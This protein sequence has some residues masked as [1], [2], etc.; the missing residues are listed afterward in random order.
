MSIYDEHPVVYDKL[1]ED[2]KDYEWEAHQVLDVVPTDS[3]SLVNFGCGTGLHDQYFAEELAVVGVDAS[4]AMLDVAEDKNPGAQYVKG[5][6]TSAM[7][8]ESFDVV[9]TLFGVLSYLDDVEDLERAVQ[10]MARHLEEDGVLVLDY[11][12][13]RRNQFEE[14]PMQPYTY[15][16]DALS[17]AR[18]G[19]TE[20]PAE[21][22]LVLRYHTVVATDSG[23]EAFSEVHSLR[24]FARRDY[25]RAFCKAGLEGRLVGDDWPL[26]V[27]ER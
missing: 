7:V 10:N 13:P 12:E 2:M 11:V 16:E 15:R 3:D 8:G 19:V 20:I 24:Q 27:A 22:E 17:V 26:W 18:T 25:E 21:D 23:V 4:D 9:V 14:G 6:I 1:Y 5:D